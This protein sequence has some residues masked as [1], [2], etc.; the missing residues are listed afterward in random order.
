MAFIGYT[1]PYPREGCFGCE[2]ARLYTT[3]LWEVDYVE[4]NMA[5]K[6]K[7]TRIESDAKEPVKSDWKPTA[8]N[9]G[10]ATRN[11]VIAFVLW[12]LAIG[13]EAFVIFWL[14]NRTFMDLF[15]LWLII[16]IVVIGGLALGANLLWK[17]ANKYDPAAKANA[18]QFFFQNQL[19]VIM[20]TIAFIPMIVLIFL[21]KDMDAKTKGIAGAVG[22]VL[23]LIVGF[24][25][26]DFNPPS[27][28]VY[29]SETNRIEQ[30]TGEDHVHWT[31]SG[32]KYH[33]YEDCSSINKAATVEIFEGTVGTAF[34]SLK[35]LDNDDPLCYWCEQRFIKENP[36]KA[37]VMAEFGSG[38][39]EGPSETDGAEDAAGDGD[40][41][42][43]TSE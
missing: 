32:T 15:L 17:K 30:L 9:K 41:N 40:S 7:V 23:Y 38:T 22:I 19:G 42:A 39:S 5:T 31:A 1:F 18:F 13:G 35:N 8:E 6:K 3:M 34:A 43:T 21:N 14:L 29:A 25:G 24:F 37:S 27:Q 33:I 12:I 20:T 26:I 28:E 2:A 11:R 16:A 10:K 36:D 4:E